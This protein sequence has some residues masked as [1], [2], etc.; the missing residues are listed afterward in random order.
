MNMFAVC[1]FLA[2][3]RNL[4][5]GL[6]RR[7]VKE[8][9]KEIGRIGRNVCLLRNDLHNSRVVCMKKARLRAGKIYSR[10]LRAIYVTSRF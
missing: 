3:K 10:V 1:V 2:G 9:C 7:E 5:S 8:A 4:I 6:A